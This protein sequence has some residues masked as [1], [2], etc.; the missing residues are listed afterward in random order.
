ML[1]PKISDRQIKIRL[2]FGIAN[3]INTHLRAKF[4]P[5]QHVSLTKLV[6]LE[7]SE[8]NLDYII[9]RKKT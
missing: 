9:I 6:L 2:Q 1:I 8:P 4:P 3:S 5:K 7:I